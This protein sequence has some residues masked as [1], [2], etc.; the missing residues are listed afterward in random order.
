MDEMKE[1]FGRRASPLKIL[2]RFGQETICSMNSCLL[3]ALDGINSQLIFSFV[4]A[5]C[6][7]VLPRCQD[8]ILFMTG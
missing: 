8:R 7:Y 1:G 5:C 3:C 2:D 6:G 4:S